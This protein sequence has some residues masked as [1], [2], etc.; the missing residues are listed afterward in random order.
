[1]EEEQALERLSGFKEHIFRRCGFSADSYKPTTAEA[2]QVI[3][4]MTVKEYQNRFSNMT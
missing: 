4:E 3:G 1:M 2:R